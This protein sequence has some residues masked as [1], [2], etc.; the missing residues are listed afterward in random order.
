MQILVKLPQDL[1]TGFFVGNKFVDIFVA[2]VMKSTNYRVDRLKQLNMFIT[3]QSLQHNLKL[4]LYTTKYL[5][6]RKYLCNKSKHQ[7]TS[8]YLSQSSRRL[9]YLFFSTSMSESYCVF[10]CSNS[11]LSFLFSASDIS[12]SDWLI[13]ELIQKL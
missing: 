13:I 3:T 5:K 1:T 9:S 4:K 2:F 12:S 8:L 7:P 6:D 11:F 10:I